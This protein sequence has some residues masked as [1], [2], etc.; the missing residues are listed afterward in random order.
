MD[1]TAAFQDWDD[2][3]RLTRRLNGARTKGDLVDAHIDLGIVAD[4]ALTKGDNQ[5]A[6]IGLRLRTRSAWLLG[7]SAEERRNIARAMGELYRRRSS[8]AHRGEVEKRG[9]DVF[10]QDNALCGRILKAIVERGR[11]PRG[12]DW[13]SIIYG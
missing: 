12:D 13:P 1:L 11:F 10:E 7:A 4:C 2:L 9:R 6:E 8:A 5:E 3:W